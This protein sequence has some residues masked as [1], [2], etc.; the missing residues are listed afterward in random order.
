MAHVPG[1]RKYVARWAAEEFRPATLVNSLFSGV[2][3]YMLEI[4]FVIS[5]T[6]LVFSGPMANQLPRALSF[7]LLGNAILLGVLTLLS[8]YAGTIGVAQ[9][10]PGAILGLAAT[11]IVTALPAQA[12]EQQFATV[13][14]MI[15]VTTLMTAVLF[16]VLGIF[17]LGGLARFLPYPVMGGFLAGTGWLLAKGGIGIMSG[18]NFGTELLEPQTLYHWVPG[19]FLGLLILGSV[20]Y[21]RWSLILPVLLFVSTLIFYL[22]TFVIKISPAQLESEGWLVGSIPAGSMSGYPLGPDMVA[23]VNWDVLWGQIPNLVPAAVICVIALLLNCGGLELVTKKDINLDRELVAAGAGNLLAGLVGGLVGYHAISLSNL[24]HNLSGGKRLVGVF[25]ALLLFVTILLGAPLLG[26]IPKLVLG[27]VLVYLG[28]GLLIEW[29]YK[30]WFNF[31]RID[32]AIIITILAVIMFSGFLNGIIL[33]LVFAIILFVVSYSRLNNVKY[34]LPGGAIRS[35]VTR[36]WEEQQLLDSQNERF[37][38]FKLQGF[39]F[40]G[41]ANN[42]SN[43]VRKLVQSK[44]AGTIRFILLDFTLVSGLDSTGLLSF[45]RILQWGEK[46]KIGLGLTGVTKSLR[47]QFIRGGMHEQPNHLLFFPTLDQGA[48][49]C[50]NQIIAETLTP[51]SANPDLITELKGI[52]G[53]GKEVEKLLTHME[54]KEYVAG[55]YLIRQ[56]DTPNSIYFIESGKVT[57]RWAGQDQNEVR[58][59]TMGGGNLVGELGFYLGIRRTADVIVN[60]PSVIYS[61]SRQKLADVERVDPESANLFH[62]IVATRLGERVVHLL[63]I[64]ENFER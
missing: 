26:Y 39:I 35:R 11:A 27:S 30:A 34:A 3:I 45:S 22:V 8:S 19:L 7:I 48:E 5:F 56:D 12:L 44:P 59:E 41:T 14:M 63:G 36:S 24:N 33:G 49:W 20:A 9:D 40:F 25:T 52:V 6:A 32:F 53:Q 50:E 61:F 51:A 46:Q 31:P 16:L 18:K 13:V 55:E 28:A 58:L 2:L 43:Q 29:V 15:V 4:I 54:C 38:L 1:I 60:E 57:A 64:V 62:Q 21:F 10:T 47:D 37:F 17:K 42:I 23:Q